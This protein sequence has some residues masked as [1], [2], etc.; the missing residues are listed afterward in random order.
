[1]HV[2]GIIAEYNPFHSGHRYHIQEIRR[3][4]GKDAYILCVMSGNWVQRG[5]AA[6]TDKWTRS[7]AALCSGADLVLELPTVWAVS[8]A[9]TFAEGG[10]SLLSST[11]LVDTLSFG[12]ETGTLQALQ[13]SAD[14][15]SSQEYRVF[16]RQHLDQGLSFP[17]ARQKAATQGIGELADCLQTANNNLGVEYLRALTRLGS[18]ISPHTIVRQGVSH[19]SKVSTSSYASASYLRQQLLSK[20]CP[21]L[22][23]FLAQE[24][25]ASLQ[26]NGLASLSTC[27]RAVFARLR[28]M[29]AEDFL[30]LPDCGEG[31]HH[32]LLEAARNSSSLD[33][34]YSHAKSR[35]YTHARIRRLVLWAFLGLTKADRPS[36][37]PYLR[38]LAMTKR[39]QALL[40]DMK[41]TA[42][43]PI[44]TKSAHVQKLDQTCRDLFDLESRCTS[45][46]DLCRFDFGSLPGKTE[47]T[48]NPVI[49]D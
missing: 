15:L 18:S 9:E 42:S 2:I 46:Y 38:V 17:V 28:S 44:L 8:S 24:D 7:R 13:S 48:S 31:L 29:Q 43:I 6:I 34:L 22:R 1:M 47:Y 12:S 33:D 19:D 3:L 36:K 35:R 25:L 21:D 11:G 40:R 37:P 39:G 20:S 45:L 26:E 23:P 30:R 14:F 27:T 4:F 41:R 32:R 10:V 49:L 16:L 5:D